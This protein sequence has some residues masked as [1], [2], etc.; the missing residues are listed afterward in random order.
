MYAI[1]YQLFDG[2]YPICLERGKASNHASILKLESA[3][4]GEGAGTTVGL[5]EGPEP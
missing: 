4:V 1:P 5:G 3:P 2:Y